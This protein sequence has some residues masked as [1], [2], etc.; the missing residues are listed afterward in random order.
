M[1]QASRSPAHGVRTKLVNEVREAK[2]GSD[3]VY[4]LVGCETRLAHIVVY[5]KGWATDMKELNIDPGMSRVDFQMKRGGTV[6]IR[7]LDQLG[8]PV[9]NARIFFQRWRGQFHYFEF[10]HVSQ[11]ADKNGV[12]EWHEAPLD[13]FTADI[14][15]PGGMEL[16]SQRLIAR[17]QEYVFNTTGALV[18]S[19]KV[20]D[21]ATKK[22]IKEFRVVPGSRYN[23][24]QTYWNSK[25]SFS[26]TNGRY[27]Y[28]Q[29]RA[30]SAKL[31]RIE[32]EG[33]E[34]A[35]SREINSTEGAV[36]IDFE[37]KPGNNILARVVSPRNRPAAG[38]RVALGVAGSQIRNRQW[39]N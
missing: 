36:T 4:R 33:Y 7:V 25:E 34:T 27:E 1:K 20:V 39:R 18:V 22:P 15:P 29:S 10:D 14:C 21:A 8:N 5:A 24:V 13:E 2:T 17:E 37:L 9:P 23:Q 30:D 26:A 19:G 16:L 38:A 28:R 32:A 6:R 3:G 35:V 11:Y 31:L 12:W